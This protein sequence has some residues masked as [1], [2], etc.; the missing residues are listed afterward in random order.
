MRDAGVDVFVDEPI[1]NWTIDEFMEVA[2]IHVV[3][4]PL[5]ALWTA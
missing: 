1:R 5:T 3:C 2:D 4:A